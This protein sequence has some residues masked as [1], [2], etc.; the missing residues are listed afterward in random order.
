MSQLQLLEAATPRFGG[1]FLLGLRWALRMPAGAEAGLLLPHLRLEKSGVCD[2]RWG[3]WLLP[4]FP[5]LL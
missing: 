1:F 3:G 2:Q 5:Q 4:F